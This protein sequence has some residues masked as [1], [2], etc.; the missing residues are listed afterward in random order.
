[1]IRRI[2]AARRLT[3]LPAWGSHRDPYADPAEESQAVRLRI[4]VPSTPDLPS[5]LGC[6]VVE[7]S[8]EYGMKILGCLPSSGCVL[9]HG[10]EWSWIVPSG[11]DVDVAWP[12]ITRYLVDAAVLVPHYGLRPHTTSSDGVVHW[13]DQA[14]PY[15]HPLLLYF[16][17]C[18]IAGVQPAVTVQ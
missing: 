14:V 1:M 15:T 13:P 7:T 17:A 9:A 11:S 2:P 18:C 10:D 12:S 16:A 5:G 8:A 6:D 3:A 4:R